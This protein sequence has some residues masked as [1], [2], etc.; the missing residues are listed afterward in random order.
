MQTIV[1]ACRKGGAGKTTLTCQLAV[2]AERAGAGPVVIIDTDPMGGLSRW[3]DRREEAAPRMVRA[4]AGMAKVLD[5][6]RAAGAQLVLVD[7]PPAMD[8]GVAEVIALADLVLIPVQPTPDDLGAVGSTIEMVVRARK[9]VI[10]IINRVKPR[11]RLTGEAAIMLSQHGTVAP[12]M[13]AD[14]TDYAAAK[15]DGL[16]A[17]EVDPEGKAAA[18]IAALWSYVASRMESAHVQG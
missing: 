5:A 1:L 17:P 16:S 8:K 14:R 18:E 2:E 13:I 3:R 11:V 15:I 12:Q 4:D 6:A 10:F 9:A 7:T